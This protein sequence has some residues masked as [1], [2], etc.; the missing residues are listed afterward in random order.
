MK[1]KERKIQLGQQR[2]VRSNRR[3]FVVY[4]PEMKHEHEDLAESIKRSTLQLIGA[5]AGL[6]LEPRFRQGF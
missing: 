5:D 1:A 2:G 6:R 3:T 4:A